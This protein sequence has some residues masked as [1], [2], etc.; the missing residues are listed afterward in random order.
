MRLWAAHRIVAP[1]HSAS[2]DAACSGSAC[3]LFLSACVS[4]YRDWIADFLKT[5]GQPCS[6]IRVLPIFDLSL[7]RHDSHHGSFGRGR[8]QRTT[9]C[10]HF[11]QNVVD[12]WSTVLF[13]MLCST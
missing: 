6:N 1:Q 8:G 10:R 7:Y 11:C 5:C 12:V 2:S 13:N 4:R 9:D 3:I